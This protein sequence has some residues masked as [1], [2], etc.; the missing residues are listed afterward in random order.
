[1][2]IAYIYF[3]DLEVKSANLNQTLN[4]L[5]VFGCKESVTFVSSWVSKKRTNDLIHF[6]SV[7]P[8][9]Q[10]AR[11][12]AKLKTRFF[13]LEVLSRILYSFCTWIYLLVKKYD[14]IYTRDP[15]LL[16]FFSHL[17][18]WTLPK[19]STIVFE[20][21]KIYSR[22]STK[23]SFEQEKRALKQVDA[24]IAIS[25][26]IKHDLIE[27]YQ[28]PEEKVLVAHDG[29]NVNNFFP[30]TQKKKNKECI[31]V[32]TGSF[33]QWKGVEI[34]VEAARTLSNTPGW[35]MI[36]AGGRTTEEVKTIQSL[37]SNYGLD[38]R[39]ECMGFLPQ[40]EVVKILHQ[41]DVAIAPNRANTISSHY[42]SPLKVFEYMATGLPIIAPNL[43][44]FREILT[45]QQTALFFEANRPKALASAML[46][47]MN[48]SD[49]RTKIAANACIESTQYTWANRGARIL[50]FIKALKNN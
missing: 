6:F 32:Y 44:A 1:M 37:I 2:R 41:A 27:E 47:L 18:S 28:I 22:T 24:I 49:L 17:P 12:P 48:D 26:G 34:L 31:F 25:E 8:H 7:D 29:Y 39:V 10:F 19:K 45:D 20:S 30:P 40:Q 9:F 38:E 14:V 46:R 13:A 36:I 5:R 23:I 50:D 16:L 11:I 15:S 3:N 21:H 42:T 33:Q 43:P 35:R 4:M